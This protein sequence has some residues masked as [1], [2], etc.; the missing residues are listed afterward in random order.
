MRYGNV[1][2]A[3]SRGIVITP[4]DLEWSGKRKEKST[5]K[6]QVE[7]LRH[8][9]IGAEKEEGLERRSIRGLVGCLNAGTKRENMVESVYTS[10]WEFGVPALLSTDS[11]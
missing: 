10:R 9:L 4:V 7:T 3:R 5:Q 2:D 1:P 11:C 8:I 6:R